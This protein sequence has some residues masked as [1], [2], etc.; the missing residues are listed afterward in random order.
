MNLID[1]T[2]RVL[3]KGFGEVDLIISFTDG[4][5]INVNNY[6]ELKEVGNWLIS[7]G[8]SLRVET[9]LSP[10]RLKNLISKTTKISEN[11]ISILNAAGFYIP[12]I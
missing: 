7:S 1:K 3:E 5:A 10:E 4:S 12:F 6:S 11:N 9:T 8:A 2:N